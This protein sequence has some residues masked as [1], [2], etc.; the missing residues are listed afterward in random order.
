LFT[1]SASIHDEYDGLVSCR[2]GKQRRFT[3]EVNATDFLIF[4]IDTDDVDDDDGGELLLVRCRLHEES[5]LDVSM[6]SHKGEDACCW[7]RLQWRRLH[8][9]TG[10]L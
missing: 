3:L 6:Q 10:D 1:S 5:T 4:F 7:L 2:L 8:I 9:A